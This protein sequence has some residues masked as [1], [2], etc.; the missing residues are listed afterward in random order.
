MTPPSSANSSPS[1]LPAAFL[2]LNELALICK[3][4][5]PVSLIILF[6]PS[7]YIS[8]SWEL[9]IFIDV[10]SVSNR[11]SALWSHNKYLPDVAPKNLTSWPV[12]L[13]PTVIAS[14]WYEGPSNWNELA[15]VGVVVIELSA[16]NTIPPSFWL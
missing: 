16:L 4:P 12:S 14:L 3:A 6:E 13:T 7:W 15:T 10:E 8:K 1:S 2:I 9:P 5:V 11:A